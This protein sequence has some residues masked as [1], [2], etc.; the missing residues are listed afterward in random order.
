MDSGRKALVGEIPN[1]SITSQEH[2][3][4]RW[5]NEAMVASC[6]LYLEKKR[7]WGYEEGAESGGREELSAAVAPLSQQASSAHD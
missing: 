1:E 4:V 3:R 6:V 5:K 7:T 2:S